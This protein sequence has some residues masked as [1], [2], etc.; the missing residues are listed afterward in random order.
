M[1]ESGL[2]AFANSPQSMPIRCL[3]CCLLDNGPEPLDLSQETSAIALFTH[4]GVIGSWR[5]GFPLSLKDTVWIMAIL[6]IGKGARL[7]GNGAKS[8]D[9]E[10]KCASNKKQP[11]SNGEVEHPK[12]R[13]LPRERP[14][15]LR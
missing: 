3:H 14:P 11:M 4:A 1:G 13:P 15:P 2:K 10:Q 8:A 6:L 9:S 5:N 7:G 12:V